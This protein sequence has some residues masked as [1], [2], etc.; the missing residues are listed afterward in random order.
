MHAAEVNTN[1]SSRW[2]SWL[3]LWRD[4]TGK[5]PQSGLNRADEVSDCRSR[6]HRHLVL[7]RCV[8]CCCFYDFLDYFF[9]NIV[10]V[11]FTIATRLQWWQLVR[12]IICLS[13]SA[14]HKHTPH[15]SHS[16]KPTYSP[17]P[18]SRTPVFMFLIIMMLFVF[19][20][21]LWDVSMVPVL[22]HCMSGLH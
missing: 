5:R 19:D 22:L 3:T 15:L 12:R 21:Q 1:P 7:V 2:C 10:L 13:P 9:L 14:T 8:F 4:L 6:T 11:L 16:W 17:K 20:L 18:S